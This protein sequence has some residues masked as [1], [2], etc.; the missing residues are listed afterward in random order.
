MC[1]EK[2]LIDKEFIDES[3]H[4]IL[5]HAVAYNKIKGVVPLIEKYKIDVNLKT[6]NNQ[7]CIMIAAQFGSLSSMKYLIEKGG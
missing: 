1:I 6:Q 2:N 4:N 5:H 7:T 3:G